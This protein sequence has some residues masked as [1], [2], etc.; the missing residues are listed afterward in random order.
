MKIRWRFLPTAL[1]ALTLLGCGTVYSWRPAVPADRRT[2]AV[3][4]FRNSAKLPGFGS[5]MARQLAR[6]FQRE[7]TFAIESAETAALEVQGEVLSVGNSSSAFDRHGS[8]KSS[9]EITALVQVT[10]V[11]RRSQKLLLDNRKYDA[12]VTYSAGADSLNA[13]RD[14]SGRLA[15]E[16]S[17][18]VVDDI[19]NL[20][21]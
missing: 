4:T 1:A 10:V 5:V 6:E 8:R 9:Y 2:V 14:A 7:G 16:L 21:W 20:K 17:R 3:P 11:D 18:R 12:S 19:L 15:D 13:K